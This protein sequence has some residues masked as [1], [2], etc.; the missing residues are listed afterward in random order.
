[1]REYYGQTTIHPIG[2]VA[3]MLL[4]MAML[5]L[6]RRYAVIP[7]IVMACFISPAQRIVILGADFNLIRIM[8]VFGF[9]R[10]LL[11]SEFEGLVMRPMDWLLIVWAATN[12]VAYTILHMS[13]AALVNRLGFSFD[14]IGLYFL[15]RCLIRSW[16]DVDR[17]VLGFILISIP[18]ALFFLLERSTGRNLFSVFGGVPEITLVREGRL[19]CQGPFPHAIMAGCFWAAVLPLICAWWWRGPGSRILAAMGV[20]ACAVIIIACASS[21]PV[22]AVLSG[23][24]A[25]SL[26]RYRSWLR[27]IC[28]TGLGVLVLLHLVML[29]PVWHLIARVSAVGGSTG[30][31]RYKLIDAA[32]NHIGEWWLFG[33]DSTAHWGRGLQDLTNHYVLEGVRGGL[34]TLALFVALIVLAFRRVGYLQRAADV[35][36][37]KYPRM[38]AWGLGVV[39]FV[40]VTSFFGVSYFGQIMMVWFLTLAMTGAVQQPAL[41]PAPVVVR[42]KVVPSERL[43]AQIGALGVA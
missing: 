17:V 31:H 38:L 5:L 1:M 13:S 27:A 25:W 12:T 9:L 41:K 33:T 10:L 40:H 23:A 16:Q 18:V 2:L 20:A 3:V 14:A 21:T 26:Y 15:F 29:K 43:P 4:G 19:R 24:L 7:M 42:R 35:T 34:L 37:E 36:G 39:L 30:H 22:L 11:R 8:V 32:V 28:W 6:P